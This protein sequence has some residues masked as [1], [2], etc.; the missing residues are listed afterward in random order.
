MLATYYLHCL[1]KLINLPFP[2]YVT[3]MFAFIFGGFESLKGSV[4]GSMCSVVKTISI[5][6]LLEVV[7]PR[8]LSVPSNLWD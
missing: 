5:G 2:S 3:F 6:Q 4:K 7:L 1:S 8:K